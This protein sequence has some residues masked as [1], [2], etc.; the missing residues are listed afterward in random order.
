MGDVSQVFIIYCAGDNV[1]LTFPNALLFATFRNLIMIASAPVTI[2][3]P[4]LARSDVAKSTMNQNVS[5]TNHAESPMVSA[6]CSTAKSHSNKCVQIPYH[7]H[8]MP[9]ECQVQKLVGLHFLDCFRKARMVY[10]MMRPDKVVEIIVRT[11]PVSK[12]THKRHT[13]SNSR[14][15]S[16]PIWN[17]DGFERRLISS[18]RRLRRIVIAMIMFHG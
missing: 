13:F 16:I 6:Q 10:R 17:I 15:F 14:Q 5:C 2:G 8:P 4:P 11:L 18:W 7:P 9:F 1:L 12:V 3:A